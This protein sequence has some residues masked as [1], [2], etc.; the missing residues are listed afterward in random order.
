MKSKK[1]K[2][3]KQTSDEEAYVRISRCRGHTSYVTHVDW[4]KDS[5]V[6]QSNCGAYEII[7]WDE[8]MLM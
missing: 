4:S 1:K 6:I 3:S 8:E 5:K 2:K 7:Y